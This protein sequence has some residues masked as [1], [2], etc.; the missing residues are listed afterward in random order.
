MRMITYADFIKHLYGAQKKASRPDYFD[1]GYEYWAL[2][3]GLVIARD[4]G[5]FGS[6]TT[7]W[8]NT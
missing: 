1:N 5:V 7:Y 8:I 3:W 4:V 6:P 2:P